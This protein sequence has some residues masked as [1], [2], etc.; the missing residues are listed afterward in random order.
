MYH[1][2]QLIYDCLSLY[3]KVDTYCKPLIVWNFD[4]LKIIIKL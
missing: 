2:I 1:L 4:N 3:V